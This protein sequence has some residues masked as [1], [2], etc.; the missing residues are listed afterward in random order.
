[1]S[2]LQLMCEAIDKMFPDCRVQ[3]CVDPANP[4]MGNVSVSLGEWI[5]SADDFP[6]DRQPD[7][8]AGK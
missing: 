1:M 2:K 6:V 8:E 7:K 3:T 4:A 5:R